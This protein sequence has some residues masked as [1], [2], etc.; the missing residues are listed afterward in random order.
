MNVIVIIQARMG[1]S[2]LPNKVLMP[3]ADKPA[4]QHVIERARMI[5]GITD[6]VLATTTSHVDDPLDEFCKTLGVPVYRGSEDD[7]LDRYYQAAILYN[8]DIIVRITGDCPLLDPSESTKVVKRLLEHNVDYVS[9]VNPPM[10]PDGLDT[11]AM[12]VAALKCTWKR[13]EKRSEREHVTLYI[14][15]NPS[16]FRIDSI[17]Y[18][19]DRSHYRLTLDEKSDYTLLQLLFTRLKESQ[20]FGF[21]DEIIEI[22]ESDWMLRNINDHIKRNEGLEKSCFKDGDKELAQRRKK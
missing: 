22:L 14:Y 5:S 15:S 10:L 2:R 1:S 16:D 11:E 8:A 12:T 7:V 6:V 9:N 4:I 17:A 13:A 19:T 21:V 20:R 18:P 3:L